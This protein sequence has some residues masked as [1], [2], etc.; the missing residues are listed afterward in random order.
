MGHFAALALFSLWSI[1]H[2]TYDSV[3]C[4][5]PAALLVD[6]LVHKR[7]VAFSR[8]WLA[9]FG[10]LIVSIPGVL[11]DRLKMSPADLA[12]NP[13]LFLGL[14]IERLL[15]L[16]MFW[17]LMFLMWKAGKIR[18]QKS[19]VRSQRSEVRAVSGGTGERGAEVILH[20]RSLTPLPL[21][22]DP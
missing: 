8:F 20:P 6:F 11:V 17:S 7:F 22:S 10:L 4:L 3:L 14:H 18:G 2:R 1:Y 21:S 13:L 19:E 16:G 5:L 15:V 12:N 9:A